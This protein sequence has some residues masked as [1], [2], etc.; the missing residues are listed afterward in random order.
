MEAVAMSKNKMKTLPAHELGSGNIFADL[1]LPDAEEHQLK[2]ALV[3]HVRR[4]I[5]ARKLTQ[6]AAAKR[7]G[8]K[9]PGR[10]CR[11]RPSPERKTPPIRLRSRN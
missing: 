2:A 1:G 8:I 9:Q 3:V 6:T 10:K 4:L 7:I 5:E 11:Y